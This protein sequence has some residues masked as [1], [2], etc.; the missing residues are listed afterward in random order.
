MTKKEPLGFKTPSM[1][2]QT[3]YEEIVEQLVAKKA[4]WEKLL[5]V[6]GE[7]Y[8]FCD[9]GVEEI[10]KRTGSNVTNEDMME[11]GHRSLLHSEALTQLTIA[12]I[13][14]ELS[15]YDVRISGIEKDLKTLRKALK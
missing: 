1:R 3:E 5:K 7:I 14:K 9:A 8:E 4:D 13:G 6:F 2:I 15:E 11:L 12:R 10:L